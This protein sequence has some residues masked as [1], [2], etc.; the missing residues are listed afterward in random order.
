[1]EFFIFKQIIFTRKTFVLHSAIKDNQSEKFNSICHKMS[2]K[3][4]V[5]ESLL[6]KYLFCAVSQEI[7]SVW[8]IQLHLL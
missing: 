7:T 5:A 8:K 4:N 1:M 6:K 3:V 2:D